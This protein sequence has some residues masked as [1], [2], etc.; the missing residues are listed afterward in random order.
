M[1]ILKFSPL[2][3]LPFLPSGLLQEL[4]PLSGQDFPECLCHADRT[5]LNMP[6]SI[7]QDFTL[8]LIMLLM[9]R[10]YLVIY[11]CFLFV[12]LSLLLLPFLSHHSH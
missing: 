9:T 12:A 10:N 2:V 1:H 5:L 8:F 6:L 3:S 7:T 11:L 4:F